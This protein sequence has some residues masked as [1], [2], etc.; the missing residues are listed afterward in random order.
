VA[1]G[2]EPAVD[3]HG[4]AVG[5]EKLSATKEVARPLNIVAI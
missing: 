3:R 1:I 2:H 5:D 4:L